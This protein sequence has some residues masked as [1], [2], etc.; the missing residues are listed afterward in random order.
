MDTNVKMEMN[1]NEDRDIQMNAKIIKLNIEKVELE[2]RLADN[3][4]KGSK[5]NVP[6]MSAKQFTIGA[7]K[8]SEN[9]GRMYMVVKSGRTKR[10]KLKLNNS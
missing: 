8:Q 2:N 10:W 4:K 6:N 5:K 7:E 3:A 1:G 9:D